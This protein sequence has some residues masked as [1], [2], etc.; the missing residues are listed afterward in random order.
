LARQDLL[1]LVPFFLLKKSRNTFKMAY[2]NMDLRRSQRQPRPRTIWEEKGA[3]SAARDP[4]ITIKTARTDK[5][6]ALKPITIR[7]L[8]NAT[9][10]NEKRLPELSK[11]DPPL[12]LRYQPSESLAIGLSE[13]NTF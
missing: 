13:V 6:T 2:F 12:E 10:L 8:F 3:L 11:Y 5:R 4:K 7:L 1:F 9:K